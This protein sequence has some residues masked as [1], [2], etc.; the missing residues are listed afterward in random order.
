MKFSIITCTYNSAEYVKE[1][2]ES[3]K[4]QTYQDF[5]HIFIDGF[6]NDSTVKIIK[7]YKKDY[8]QKVKLFQ[9]PPKG[10]SN[11]MNIGIKKSSGKY[12]IH[13]H[14]DDCFYKKN[15]LKNV[16]KFLREKKYPDW[17]YGKAS[18]INGRK[19]AIGVFPEKK[20][21][22]FNKNPISNYILKF[23]NFVPHQAV[24]IKKN[25]FL[26]YGYF[27]ESITSV[28]DI[29][30]WLRIRK[31]TN[32]FFFN[33]IICYYTIRPGSQS[34]N[35]K[36]AKEN[37]QNLEKIQ[38]KYMNVVEIILAKILKFFISKIHKKWKKF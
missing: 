15:V 38:K 14:S 29:E 2:I 6:S 34:C 10:I 36:N 3:V 5:E 35:T 20:I 7:E 4:D 37:K 25:I 11:A 12:L 21:T 23:F 30:Y 18:V 9:F 28:M 31:K 8:P 16:K 22:Q 32:W 17:I 13:L 1:N 24:F 19:E 27:D 26:K 33:D